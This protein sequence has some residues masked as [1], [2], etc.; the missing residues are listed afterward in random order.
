MPKQL[1]DKAIKTQRLPHKV[2]Q[3][4]SETASSAISVQQV[5]PV[6]ENRSLREEIQR[7]ARIIDNLSI[8]CANKEKALAEAEIVM[9]DMQTALNN[10]A[11]Q[12]VNDQA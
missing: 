9:I 1:K 11:G 8:R 12:R 10:L 6:L 7:L 5:D 2:S 3:P 4:N